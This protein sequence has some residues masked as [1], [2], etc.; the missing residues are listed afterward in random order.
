M[1]VHVREAWTWWPPSWRGHSREADLPL[2]SSAATS[3]SR[4]QP[5]LQLVSHCRQPGGRA[6]TTPS[7]RTRGFCPPYPSAASEFKHVLLVVS[8]LGSLS[9]GESRHLRWG[10]AGEWLSQGPEPSLVVNLFALWLMSLSR[11]LALVLHR[12]DQTLANA[13]GP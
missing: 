7:G 4:R 2:P 8:R 13:S 1:P 9:P 6:G 3:L 10:G 5:E 12:R 11:V